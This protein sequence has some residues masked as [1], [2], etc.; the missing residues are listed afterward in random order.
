ML[1]P[2][3]ITIKLAEAYH[4]SINSR[5]SIEV[6][7]S[8]YSNLKGA[9]IALDFERVIFC[10]RSSAQ[11]IVLIKKNMIYN[12]T[13]LEYINVDLNVNK[14][15]ELAEHKLTRRNVEISRKSFSSK[16]D[17]ESFMLAF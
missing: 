10:S 1:N 12:N 3:R 4:T 6:L 7:L 2:T 15:L 13:R 11:Q 17:L 8:K 9:V 16:S 5:S 14:M